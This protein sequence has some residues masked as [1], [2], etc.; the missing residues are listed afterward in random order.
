[1]GDELTYPDWSAGDKITAELLE[2]MQV[3]ILVKSA[4]QTA[5]STT[6]IEDD[7]FTITLEDDAVYEIV[8]VAGIFATFDGTGNPSSVNTDWTFT[9]S[10]HVG[11]RICQG[12]FGSATT[13]STNRNNTN[14]VSAAHAFGTDRRYG[15]EEDSGLS[16]GIVEQLL[17]ITEEG[18]DWTFRFARGNTDTASAGV[19]SM[20]WIMWWR[21]A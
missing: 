1:M 17:V 19:N 4:A 13:G 15:H 18:G 11:T 9:G 12:P 10:G 16:A 2:A 21:V 20:S 14:M 3:Q 6:L 8:L 5:P 7:T